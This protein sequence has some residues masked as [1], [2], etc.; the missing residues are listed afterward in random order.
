M[1]APPEPT[2]K[3]FVSL[4]GS[5]MSVPVVDPDECAVHLVAD[6]E[7]KETCSPESLFKPTVLERLLIR[8][9]IC[10]SK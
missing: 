7:V 3:A 8:F 5:S 9:V 6:P 1:D 2:R 10:M 4:W